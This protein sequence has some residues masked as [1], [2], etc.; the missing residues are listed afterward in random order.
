[1][2]Y[3]CMFLISA[4]LLS[5]GPESPKYLVSE[6]KLDEALKVLQIMYAGNKKKAPEDFPVNV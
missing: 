3:A 5:F 6:G 2:V 1:M 4:G